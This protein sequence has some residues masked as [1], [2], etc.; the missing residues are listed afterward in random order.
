MAA[1]KYKLLKRLENTVLPVAEEIFNG[2]LVTQTNMIKSAELTGNICKRLLPSENNF[3]LR[4]QVINEG[5]SFSMEHSPTYDMMKKGLDR[6]RMS[7]VIA[8]NSAATQVISDSPKR[9]TKHQ[10]L[11]NAPVYREYMQQRE[12]YGNYRPQIIVGCDK[13]G[14]IVMPRYNLILVNKCGKLHV[15]GG[16]ATYGI[17]IQQWC[18]EADLKKTVNISN[19]QVS[20]HYIDN[21]K[22]FVALTTTAA[23]V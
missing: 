22:Q 10:N 11:L 16:I 13:E 20:T 12:E 17:N 18:A 7:F 6:N 21:P 5:E 1:P 19:P 8:L 14:A 15:V 3:S 4:V 23:F 2:Q 9:A